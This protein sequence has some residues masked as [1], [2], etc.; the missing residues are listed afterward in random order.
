MVIGTLYTMNLYD[1]LHTEQPFLTADDV[2]DI[3][4]AS[5]QSIR[6]QARENAS[7]LGFPVTYIGSRLRIP[8][9]PFLNYIGIKDAK[10]E[11][12]KM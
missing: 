5:A 12:Q 4:G 8:R 2:A 6:N 11:M 9:I 7:L 10:Y 3:I 1:M